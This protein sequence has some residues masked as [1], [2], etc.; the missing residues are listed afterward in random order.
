MRPL[1]LKMQAFG[2]YAGLATVD[3]RRALASGL[4]GIY[5]ATGAGKSSIFSAITFA[6]FGEAA[7]GEQQ[8]PG[9]QPVQ[10]VRRGEL[11]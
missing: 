6:L 10:P 3:F 8:H 4:F 11:G 9:R 7:D 1:I 5:G 2:P